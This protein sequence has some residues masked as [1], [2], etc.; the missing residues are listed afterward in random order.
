MLSSS[1][2]RQLLLAMHCTQ[3]VDKI[4]MV[5]ALWWGAG[6]CGC[7]LAPKALAAVLGYSRADAR[8]AL[9]V[10]VDATGRIIP[11]RPA[12]GALQAGFDG[13]GVGMLTDAAAAAAR[14]VE[15]AVG[16]MLAG[17]EAG[18]ATGSGRG[19]DAAGA[20]MQ[21]R[22]EQVQAMSPP[23][24]G[25]QTRNAASMPAV[26]DLP[27]SRQALRY[28]LQ[29]GSKVGSVPCLVPLPAHPVIR[30]E[31]AAAP[32][33][34]EGGGGTDGDLVL[35]QACNHPSIRICMH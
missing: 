34:G 18:T 30:A 20:G 17:C 32:G 33:E 28:E 19:G 22:V 12:A 11:G 16:S 8:A 9:Q 3:A 2:T 35:A 31:E 7:G 26:E 13:I 5:H 25:S 10:R 4:R 14:Q 6:R 29:L 1:H 21:G 27:A 23:P 15:D 24:A